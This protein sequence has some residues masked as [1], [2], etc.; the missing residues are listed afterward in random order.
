MP[1]LSMEYKIH[2]PVMVEEVIHVLNLREDGLY[3]DATLGCGGHSK[4]I[5]RR[6]GNR[7]RLIGLDRD[8]RALECAR[9]DINDERVM[10]KKARFSQIKEVAYEIGIQ[11]ADGILFDLGVSMLQLKD[12]SRG[13]SFYSNERLD[14]RMDQSTSLTAWEVVNKYPQQK[15][16]EIFREYGEEPFYRRVAREIVKIRSQKTI[17]SCREL[18]DLVV[19]V[20]PKRGRTHP[21]TQIFQAIRMEINKERQELIEG[22]SQAI[23]LLKNNGRICVIS[24]H[25]GEDRLVKKFFREH[26]SMGSLIILTKKPILPSLEEIA[27]NPSARSARLRGGEKICSN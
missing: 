1:L 19:R 12:M 11:K 15:L 27:K 9:E 8:E 22:L 10:L 24:Y 14:M 4:A 17:D 20:I 18:S 21:A 25:S 13:F 26:E 2:R 7:G 16:E 5:L 23:Q 6:L 3:I